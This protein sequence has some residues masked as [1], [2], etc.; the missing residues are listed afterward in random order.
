MRLTVITIQSDFLRRCFYVLAVILSCLCSD[1]RISAQT[2]QVDPNEVLTDDVTTRVLGFEKGE[3]S[4]DPKNSDDENELIKKKRKLFAEAVVI[5]RAGNGDAALAKLE[6][7]TK[8]DASLPP[9]DVFLARLC[10][11]VNDP[12]VVKLGLIVL[13]RAAGQHPD[14]PEP[15]LMFGQLALL[16][17]RLTD[18]DV[19]FEKADQVVTG[20]ASV[21]PKS[22]LEL[23][24][25][26]SYGGRVSVCEQRQNWDQGLIAV[27]AWLTYD[28]K[29][30]VALFR[31]GRLIFMQNPK[32]A[33]NVL[34]AR[35]LFEEAHTEAAMD[36]RG[37]DE[38]VSVPPAELVLLE[39]QTANGNIEKAAEEIALLDKRAADWEADKREGSRV[40]ST[41]SQWYL[42]QGEF[43]TA[44]TYAAK[45]TALDRDS[46]ALRQLTAVLHYYA[47]DPEAEVEFTKMNQEQP[48]DFFAANFLALVLSDAKQANALPDNV[49]RA[50]A[51]RIAEM[52]ARLNPRS[53]VALAT[54][55]WTYFNAGR[56]N[57]AAQ[58]FAAMEQ[59]QNLQV[60]PDTAYYMARTFAALPSAQYP[61]ALGRSKTLLELAVASNGVFRYRKAAEQ[62][63][64]ALGGFV[65]PRSNAAV[66]TVP[67]TS[68]AG[69][70]KQN[71]PKTIGST[72]ST[73]T[74][75]D[76]KDD[77]KDDG[78]NKK[79]M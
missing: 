16:E 28:P 72:T 40:Y 3:M 52:N 50:K 38:L 75:G 6:E 55:G 20:R 48:D 69:A 49:K 11:A 17:G 32:S 39:L 25:K 30:P 21:L 41:I 12:N 73:V 47:D 15:Y 23:Y 43:K 26:N 46:Q 59:Q 56:I 34:E 36:T 76:D 19:L 54:L 42:G 65:P 7:A 60:A 14:A 18:A 9:A 35:K 70:G 24:L 61:N 58:L 62:W 10:F 13:N 45:A 57:E 77:K 78:E 1:V 51:V 53:P 2:M 68:D 4:V 5:F 44:E 66:P 74:S 63:L 37:K 33:S 22:K 79:P 64:T 29:D 71:E 67:V 27:N 8:L 31:K